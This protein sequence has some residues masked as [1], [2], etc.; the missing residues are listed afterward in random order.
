[1]RAAM[2]WGVQVTDD[3]KNLI[4]VAITYSKREAELDAANLGGKVVR[5]RDVSP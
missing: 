3:N 1:M 5:V 2:K 4:T